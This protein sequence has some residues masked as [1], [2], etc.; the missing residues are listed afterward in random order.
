VVSMRTPKAE[1]KLEAAAARQT[2]R[3]EV[4]ERRSAEADC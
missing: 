4:V 3:L 2:C 1:R